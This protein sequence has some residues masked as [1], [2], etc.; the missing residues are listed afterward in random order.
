MT[1][2]RLAYGGPPKALAKGLKDVTELRLSM[3]APG[4]QGARF[5]K[6]LADQGNEVTDVRLSMANGPAMRDSRAFPDHETRPALLVSYVYLDGFDKHR[7]NLHFR[8][9]VMDSGAF[10]AWKSGKVID[11]DRYTDVCKERLEQDHQ[12]TEVFSLDVIGDW[13]GGLANTERMWSRGVEAIPTYHVGEPW[14]VLTEMAASYPKLALGGMVGYAKKKE[15]VEQCFAR[16]WPKR[17]H[18]F[19]VMSEKIVMAFPFESVD[20][21]NWELGPTAFGRWSAFDGAHLNIRG[22]EQNLRPEVE[23]VLKLER[24][25]KWRWRKQLA[26]LRSGESSSALATG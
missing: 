19:G 21:S 26:Q 22:G 25:V 11:V 23:R 24:K 3:G 20:A 17:I 1:I 18:G 2:L 10:S 15:W 7:P 12:L 14:E 16:I 4:N 9:W 5:K 6:A 8:D 13:R